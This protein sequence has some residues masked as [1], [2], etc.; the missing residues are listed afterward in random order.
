MLGRI[1]KIFVFQFYKEDPVY[2]RS[3]FAWQNK[4]K[5]FSQICKEVPIYSRS[6]LSL[7][8]DNNKDIFFSQFCKEDPVHLSIF[9]AWQYN[10]N[11]YFFKSAKKTQYIQRV[12]LCLVEFKKILISSNLLGRPR[13]FI[14]SGVFLCLVE[15]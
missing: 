13:I 12:F 15:K 2:T 10:R 9:F 11:I 7:V 5:I 4:K 14:I 6:F 8:Y 3:F 1:M